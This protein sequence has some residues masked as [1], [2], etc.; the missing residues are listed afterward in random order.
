MQ[1]G[2]RP[3]H[4]TGLLKESWAKKSSINI[5]VLYTCINQFKLPTLESL[6][7]IF[8]LWYGE[9]LS[10]LSKSKELQGRECFRLAGPTVH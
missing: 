6:Q 1:A 5:H 2:P 4:I 10:W 3:G 7:K 9:S 8:N